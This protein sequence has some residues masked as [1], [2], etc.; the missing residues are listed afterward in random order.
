MENLVY[1][2][3]INRIQVLEGTWESKKNQAEKARATVDLLKKDSN[4]LQ[5][6]E[7]VLKHL[8]DRLAKK[9]LSRMDKLVTYGLNTVFPD[10]DLRFESALEERGKKIWINLKTI[11]GENE[12]DP[13]S[14]SSVSVIES[15]ILRLLCI[16]K[17]KR[18]PVLIMDETFG[19][20]HVDYIDNVSQLIKE[21][22]SKLNMDI[23]LVTH[24]Y[25][26]AESADTSYRIS[27]RNK[28]TGIEKV[29]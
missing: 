8:I 4:I 2:S 13:N 1:D 7:K 20:L 29:K 21:L 5:K 10:K 17:L 14:K 22:A 16:Y 15:F 9:D 19:A 6:T 3:V 12:V 11:H 24:N 25:G 26:F 28:R 27:Q 18:A 23:L